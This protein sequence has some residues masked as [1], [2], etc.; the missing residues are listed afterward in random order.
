MGI[1]ADFF[2]AD[3]GL[4]VEVYQL[5]AADE[6]WPTL[7][8]KGVDPINF[9]ILYGVLSG[10]ED[11]S[12]TLDAFKLV[13]ESAEEGAAEEVEGDGEDKED[14]EEAFDGEP[15]VFVVP[16]FVIEAL[17]QVSDDQLPSL[18]EAW[19][20]TEEMTRDRWSAADATRVLRQLVA[21]ARQQ[22]P[23]GKSVYL[24]LSF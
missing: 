17:G 13:G 21:F 4:G 1:Y 22:V 2:I 10:Q 7:A 5:S 24:W 23:P 3:S 9:A 19:A 20:A 15:Q 16:P 18:A 12:E 8:L 6:R 14:E 11:I